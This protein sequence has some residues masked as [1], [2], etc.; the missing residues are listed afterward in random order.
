MSLSSRIFTLFWLGFG[1]FVIV[2]SYRLGLGGFNNPGA[3]LMPFLLG[4]LLILFSLT[5]FIMSFIKKR[6]ARHST[7]GDQSRAGYYKIVLVLLG[8]FVYALILEK[9]GFVMTT[10]IFLFLLFR[11]IGNKW[12][13]T[14]FASTFT[15][16]ATYFVFTFFGVRFPAGIFKLWG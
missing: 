15:V 16:F 5:I 10:W 9:L 11:A 12:T 1:V 4:I 6:E 13:T 14:F 2:F 8:L 3:G 7:K